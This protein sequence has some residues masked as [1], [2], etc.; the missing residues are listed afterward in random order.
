M[1]RTFS[2]PRY[3]AFKMR[4]WGFDCFPHWKFGSKN[5]QKLNSLTCQT[6]LRFRTHQDL[7]EN[8]EIRNAIYIYIYII[9]I[10]MYISIIYMHYYNIIVIII[11]IIH[12]YNLYFYL[13]IHRYIYIY[14]YIHI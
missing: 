10:Y 5:G 6:K 8:K 11:I 7:I 13:H 12:Y 9:Y 3:S 2:F 14:I 1:D 4:V